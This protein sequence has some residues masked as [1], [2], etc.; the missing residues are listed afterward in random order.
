VDH[1]PR[2]Y[3]RR[4][5][6]RLLAASLIL[7]APASAAT[8][9]VPQ[10]LGK[11]VAAVRGR[12]GLGVLLPS[13]L[14]SESAHVYPGA[15]ARRGHYDLNLGAAPGC[16]EATACFVAAFL[17]DRTRAAATGDARVTLRGGRAGFYT[18]SHCGASCAA[19]QIAFKVRGVLYT[20][21][22]QGASRRSLVAM[23]NSA[24]RAGP[25]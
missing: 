20:L 5:L 9:D 4:V 14:S 15:S 16:D 17:G 2:R 3:L 8:V 11:R 1:G 25:R 13:R 22:V 7:A 23:A 10:T 18:R 12:S 6:R 24:L 19:P 21:Q